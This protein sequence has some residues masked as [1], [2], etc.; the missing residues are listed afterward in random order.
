M[1]VINIDATITLK[2]ILAFIIEL[3]V[4]VMVIEGGILTRTPVASTLVVA[5]VITF[6]AVMTMIIAI[7]IALEATTTFNTAI[8]FPVALPPRIQTK[9]RGTGQRVP[10]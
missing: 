8:A 7:T 4:V 2:V 10:G 5:A 1:A 3:V 6:D 9:N